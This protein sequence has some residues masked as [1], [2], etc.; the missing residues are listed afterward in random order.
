MELRH[1]RYFSAVADTCHFSRAAEQL[2]VAQPAL[3]YTIQQLEGELDVTLF[4]RTTRQV[5]LTAA[6]E[7]FRGETE[8]IL[9]DVDAAPGPADQF[10]LG[11]R[12]QP[13]GG[14]AD[15]PVQREPRFGW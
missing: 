6:G 14:G 3:S 10:P 5:A 12:A 9:A 15:V 8:R 1:L 13:L 2:H 4:N 11:H 7:F